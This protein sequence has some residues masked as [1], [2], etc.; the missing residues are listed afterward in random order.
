MRPMDLV[1]VRRGMEHLNVMGIPK[2][3]EREALIEEAIAAIHEDGATALVKPI[4]IK[5][6]GGFG[7][8]R[9]DGR[10]RPRH[11]HVVF[12]IERRRESEDVELGTDH[13]YLLECVRDAKPVKVRRKRSGKEIVASA[14]LLRGI[15]ELDRQLE[16]YQRL[17]AWAL[18]LEV[19]SH[20]EAVVS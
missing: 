7:D 5:N 12:R 15:E 8:Q 10:G 11:G 2:T 14:N 17:Q 4:G 16:E 6:Y 18:R 3:P 13:I 20:L 9:F 19:G 1:R